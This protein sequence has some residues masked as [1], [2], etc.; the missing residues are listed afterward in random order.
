MPNDAL[1]IELCHTIRLCWKNATGIKGLKGFNF[2]AESLA[3]YK[4]QGLSED[5]VIL[6]A[7]IWGCGD[8]AS[9]LCKLLVNDELNNY[10]TAPDAVDISDSR[11]LEKELLAMKMTVG[12]IVARMNVLG[13][14]SGSTHSYVFLGLNRLSSNEPLDGHIYQTNIGC[15]EAFDLSAWIGDAK[16]QKLVD[17]A[18]HLK[19]LS[20]EIFDNPVDSYQREYMLTS[21]NLDPS[22]IEKKTA[23][24]VDGVRFMWRPVPPNIAKTNLK[25]L[26]TTS[27][28]K[29]WPK[30]T[31]AKGA[32]LTV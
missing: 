5:D 29:I 31:P 10:Q 27:P 4:D 3:F 26:R 12:C 7:G 28:V 25:S 20:T 32:H 2:D 6:N 1:D 13:Q 17:L 22:E 18:Q 21:T 30:V 19:G 14:K 8:S 11:R 24:K 16:F 9:R 15:A 23:N